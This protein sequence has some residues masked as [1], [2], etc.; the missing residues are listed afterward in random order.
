[1]SIPFALISTSCGSSGS[2][3]GD[4]TIPVETLKAE[5]AEGLESVYTKLEGADF[6][7]SKMGDGILDEEDVSGAFLKENLFSKVEVGMDNFG[8]MN[9]RNLC[10]GQGYDSLL[11]SLKPMKKVFSTAFTQSGWD[12]GKFKSPEFVVTFVQLSVFP[13]VVDSELMNLNQNFS[14]VVSAVGSTCESTFRN[15]LTRQC[16]WSKMNASVPNWW[17]EADL[18]GLGCEIGRGK[19]EMTSKV[20]SVDIDFF[21]SPFLLNQISSKDRGRIVARSVVVLPQRTLKTVFVIEVTAVRNGLV[22]SASDVPSLRD[23]A[24]KATNVA[25]T[26]TTKWAE[27][28]RQE[29]NLTALIAKDLVIFENEG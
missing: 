5:L 11:K 14:D 10:R 21:N 20:S 25:A 22:N 23:V 7:T 19:T 26:L 29:F 1:M 13:K 6:K 4:T 18:E 16:N 2:A 3:G 9:S 28:I 15:G 27:T 8:Y 17:N 24:S 12:T